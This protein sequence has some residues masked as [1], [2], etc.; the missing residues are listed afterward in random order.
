MPLTPTTE[1]EDVL[2]QGEFERLRRYLNI[3]SAAAAGTLESTCQVYNLTQ[4]PEFMGK[5]S[6][7]LPALLKH[8][9]RVWL[10]EASR[11]MIELEALGAMGFSGNSLA[12]PKKLAQKAPTYK[13]SGDGIHVSVS[14]AVFVWALAGFYKGAANQSEAK[15]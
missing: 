13:F 6:A 12:W 14:A 2:N 9:S 8:C 10:R 11:W 3:G 7:M 5:G 4:N 15:L 1:F